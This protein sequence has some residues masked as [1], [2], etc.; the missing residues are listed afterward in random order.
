[1]LYL[2]GVDDGIHFLEAAKKA[3]LKKPIIALKGGRTDAGGKAAHSHTGSMAGDSTVMTSVFRQ[4]GIIEAKSASDLY[5]LSMA[6]DNLPLPK[7]DRVGIVTLGGGW[8]VLTTDALV[9]QG[10]RLATLDNSVIERLDK[11]LPPFWSRSNPIDLVGQIL[12]DVYIEAVQ[13]VAES[14]NVD[15]VICLGMIGV[16]NVGV[17]TF[18]SSAAASDM[19]NIEYYVRQTQERYQQT[20]QDILTRFNELMNQ[21]KKPII[22]VSLYSGRRRASLRLKAGYS[23]VVYTTPEKAVQS[24][25]AMYNYHM[26]LKGHGIEE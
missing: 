3:T 8:G 23:E 25:V 11:L 1:M 15:A 12:P 21:L 13:V 5:D 22:N 6:F 4:S 24:L 14:K 10:L 9:E 7:G 26:F 20:E 17:R 2:E 16:S 18:L 19:D